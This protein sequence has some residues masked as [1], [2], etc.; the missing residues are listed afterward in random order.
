MSLSAR[1]WAWAVREVHNRK[2]KP[3]EKLVLLCLAEHE[4]PQLGYAFP[5]QERIA[6][7]TGQSSR[8]VREHLA[9]LEIVGAF[10]MEKRRSPKGRWMHNVYVLEVPE[11]FRESDPEW[12]REQGIWPE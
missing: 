3:G 6:E 1:N 5:S 10:F 4:N 11:K 8:T 9:S 7:W 12:I 2:I